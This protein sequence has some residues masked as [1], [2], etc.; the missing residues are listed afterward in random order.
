MG[1]KPPAVAR[2]RGSSPPRSLPPLHSPPYVRFRGGGGGGRMGGSEGGSR[3][4]P[5]IRMVEAL[6]EAWRERV[7]ERRA[8]A[9]PKIAP[10]PRLARSRLAAALE[11]RAAVRAGVR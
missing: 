5:A 3:R 4:G 10:E 11:A 8:L 7:T 6:A 1:V 2:A 9:A